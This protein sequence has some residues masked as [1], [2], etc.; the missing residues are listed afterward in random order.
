M[1]LD[2]QLSY[3]MFN[4]SSHFWATSHYIIYKCH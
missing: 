4:N 2:W 3:E 1:T